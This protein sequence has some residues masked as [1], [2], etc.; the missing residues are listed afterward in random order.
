M[1]SHKHPYTSPKETKW[2]SWGN[3]GEQGQ[4]E[5]TECSLWGPV[6]I[7]VSVSEWKSLSRVRLFETPWTVAH[8]AL[9]CPW[10]SP[11]KNTRVGCHSLLQGIFPN[12]GLNPTLLFYLL[13]V[14]LPL[15]LY[16]TGVFRNCVC[17]TASTILLHF[18]LGWIW[19]AKTGKHL[20]GP[21]TL[22]Q[23]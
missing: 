18:S 23:K 21:E 7:L 13:L 20:R 9:L 17:V 1:T 10:D 6:G 8:Q 12:Q 2:S 11:G 3:I 4:G 16:P 15:G 22:T 5:C 19:R 14:L